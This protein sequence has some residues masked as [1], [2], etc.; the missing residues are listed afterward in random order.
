MVRYYFIY[1]KVFVYC[2][3][4]AIIYTLRDPITNEI[5]YIGKT[6]RTL[7]YRLTQH[8]QECLK[9]KMIT[10]KNN[11]IWSLIQQETLPVIEEL[12]T[13]ETE[14]WQDLEKFWI[15]QFKVWGFRLTNMTDGG[16]GNQNQIMSIESRIKRSNS[17]KGKSRPK[18]VAEK[19]SKSHKGKKLSEST[20]EKLR[21]INLG[22]K[23]SEESKAKRHKAV[24]KYSTDNQVLGEYKSLMEASIDTNTSRGSIQNACVGRCKTAGGFKWSYK[25]V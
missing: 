19:I 17:L 9:R 2:N 24:I 16:D 21:I 14:N 5:R 13:T 1:P 10:Y 4:K 6:K 3:M 15:A 11:W 20:K 22:K 25:I 18:E 12:E 23:Y 7:N 8:I